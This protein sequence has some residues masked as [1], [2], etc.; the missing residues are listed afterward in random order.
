[1]RCVLFLSRTDPDM[2][3]STGP[4]NFVL[5]STTREAQ[6]F[7]SRDNNTFLGIRDPKPLDPPEPCARFGLHTAT[8]FHWISLTQDVVHDVCSW[9]VLQLSQPCACQTCGARRWYRRVG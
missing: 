4:G 6:N 2:D 1:M 8:P 7:G 9:D 3:S 5:L